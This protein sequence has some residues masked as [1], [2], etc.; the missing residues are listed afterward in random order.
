MA[1]PGVRLKWAENDPEILGLIL[2][3]K[4]ICPNGCIRILT[5][6]EFEKKEAD[7]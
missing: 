5:D 3:A 2:E 7:D 4:G 1:Y 6:I